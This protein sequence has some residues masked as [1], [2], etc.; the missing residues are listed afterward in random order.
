MDLQDTGMDY[1]RVVQW[2]ALAND[3]KKPRAPW[4]TGNILTRWAHSS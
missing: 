1:I 3:V 2:W 4:K